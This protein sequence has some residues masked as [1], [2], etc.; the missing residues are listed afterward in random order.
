MAS[1]VIHIV[2]AN[3]INKKLQKDASKL[4]IGTIAPDI[5]KE[6]NETKKN[7]HFLD[8]HNIP[9][10]DKFLLK[11]Q[12]NLSDDFVLGYYIHL[13]VDY[14]WFKYFLTEVYDERILK[15]LDGSIVKCD[16]KTL[17][18]YIYNDYTNLNIQ[19]IKKMNMRIKY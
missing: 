19:L 11:Y 14:L 18:T 3:E 15:K 16:E 6:V 12:K 4:L 17:F 8:D 2:V 1:S 9:N 5:S 13:Y 10:L 7:S